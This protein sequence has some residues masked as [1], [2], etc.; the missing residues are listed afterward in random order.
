MFFDLLSLHEERHP[1][2]KLWFAV[3]NGAFKSP[4]ARMRFKRTGLKPGVPDC[5][6]P[7]A[8]GGYHGMAIEFKAPAVKSL[9]LARG[10]TS[11]QQ[12]WWIAQ[13]KNQG[14]YV[15]LLDDAESA[16]RFAVSYDLGRIKRKEKYEGF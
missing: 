4:V 11:K 2:F 13:L 3:P 16:L 15:L 5:L 9:G 12:K 10:T 8:R 1:N 7:V 6:Y 14:W